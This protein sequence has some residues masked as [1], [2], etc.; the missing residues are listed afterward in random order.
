MGPQRPRRISR[1]R[2][3]PTR[4]GIGESPLVQDGPVVMGRGL[5]VPISPPGAPPAPTACF[6]LASVFQDPFNRPR[7]VAALVSRQQLLAWEQ[8]MVGLL[9]ERPLSRTLRRQWGT[10]ANL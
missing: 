9:T 10:S 6:S 8:P 5:R 1:W 4:S 2:V 3:T 7:T